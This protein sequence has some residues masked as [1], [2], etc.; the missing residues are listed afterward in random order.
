MKVVSRMTCQELMVIQIKAS[1]VMVLMTGEQNEELMGV[2]A[3]IGRSLLAVMLLSG[4]ASAQVFTSWVQED[5]LPKLPPKSFIVMDCDRCFDR[6]ISTH[7]NVIVGLRKCASVHF[8]GS[9]GFTTEVATEKLY[10]N[11]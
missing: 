3:L 8:L 10:S 2:G 11:G 9:R 4:S 1:V 5:L 7:G 6:Q